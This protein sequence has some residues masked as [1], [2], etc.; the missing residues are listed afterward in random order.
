MIL[1][2]IPARGG[3][4]GLPGKN[5][6]SIEGEPMIVYTIRAARASHRIDRTLVST[7][8]PEIARVARGSGAAVPFLRPAEL[9]ADTTPTLPVIDHAVRMVEASGEQVNVVVTL[10]P[11]SP[12]RTAA[13]IDAALELL[14][15]S[16][17]RSVVAVAPLGLPCNVVAAVIDGQLRRIPLDGSADARRQAAPPAVRITG[18]IYVTRRGLLA[19]GRILDDAPAVLMTDARSAIDV[20]DLTSLRAA[21]RA[22]RRAAG[23]GI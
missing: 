19:E 3:S 5:L 23:E 9:A 2:V 12:M 15:S 16:G 14:E 8:D 10:Q 4:R 20:D 13:Q 22:A 17:A 6:R 1:A 7:D 21:R 18:A 11:T